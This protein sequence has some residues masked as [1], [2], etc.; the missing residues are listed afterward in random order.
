MTCEV[1]AGVN[2]EA[3]FG[4]FSNSTI[5][6][7]FESIMASLDGNY[8]ARDSTLTYTLINFVRKIRDT[9]NQ[10]FNKAQGQYVKTDSRYEDAGSVAKNYAMAHAGMVLN[11]MN[12]DEQESVN[13]C[14]QALKT[15]EQF[16]N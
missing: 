14:F 12:R 5:N 1:N 7:I 10:K 3:Y 16:L 6:A 4:E 13:S 11:M 8:G 9:Y 15:E 2:Y